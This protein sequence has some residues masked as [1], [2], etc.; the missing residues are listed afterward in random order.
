MDKLPS[1]RNTIGYWIWNIFFVIS[2]PFM[3]AFSMLFTVVLWIFSSLSI[4]L[5]KIF[6]IFSPPK[7]K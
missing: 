4:L 3:V 7:N 1:A 2:Y 5:T 6:K